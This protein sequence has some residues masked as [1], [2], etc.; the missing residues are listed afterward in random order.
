MNGSSESSSAPDANRFPASGRLLGLDFGTRRIGVAVSTS[1]RSIASPL[2][3]Y[4]RI[5]EQLDAV[6]L[7]QVAGE[8]Q[9]VG[10][11]VGLPVHMSGDEGGMARAAREFG[12]WAGVATGLP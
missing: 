11:V 4:T 2:E 8:N 10:L 3:N 12:E 7:R 5:N 6:W 9:A 1:N